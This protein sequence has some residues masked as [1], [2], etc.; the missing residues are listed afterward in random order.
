[1][2]SQHS[3]Q[4]GVLNEV[5]SFD[6]GETIVTTME[7]VKGSVPMVNGESHLG[8]TIW[9]GTDSNKILI[10]AANFPELIPNKKILK[11]TDEIRQ[12]AVVQVPDQVTQ[13]VYHPDGVFVSLKN[14]HL[15]ILRRRNNGDWNLKDSQTIVINADAESISSVVPISNSIYLASGRKINVLTSNT[16]E[17]SK[18]FE[19]ESIAS[20]S[21]GAINLMTHS[22]IGLWVSV[23]QSSVISL[24]HTET[25]KHLQ[26]INIA[27]NVLRV[28]SSQFKGEST[29]NSTICVT[30]LVASRG[31]LWVGTNVGISLTIPLPRLEGVPIISGGVSISYHAHFGPITFLLPLIPKSYSNTNHGIV[32]YSQSQKAATIIEEAKDILKINEPQKMTKVSPSNSTVSSSSSSSASDHQPILMSRRKTLEKQNSIDSPFSAAISSKFRAQFTSSP[33]VLRRQRF[34]DTDSMRMTQTLPRSLGSSAG[35]FS[36]SIH[37]NTSSSSSS[38]GSE[39]NCCDVYGL[40]GDL[41]FVKEDY[42]AED[43]Q[44]NIMD[45]AYESLRRSNPELIPVKVSTLDRRMRMKVARPRSLDLSNWSVDSRSSSLYTSSGSEESMALR[46]Q[47]L[48]QTSSGTISRNSSSASRKYHTIES[49]LIPSVITE[50]PRESS[51][52]DLEQHHDQS[53]SLIPS[54]TGTLRKKSS[55]SNGKNIKHQQPLPEIGG[56][57]T[58]ITLTGGRGY[59][60]WR[61]VWCN[62]TT[63]EKQQRSGSLTNAASSRVPNSNDAHIV[64]WEKKL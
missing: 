33:V 22:G 3:Q 49:Q 39:Q 11:D 10:Y 61:H 29:N 41:I 16:G 13:I 64:V 32:T 42:E 36:Q 57:R 48:T 18:T 4:T 19:I 1:M 17:L 46:M 26:D 56:K 40:Y 31:L 43:G 20:S 50:Q 2:L 55:S 53:P 60:N 14:G 24:Y 54:N 37:S 47:G 34:K 38:Q 30:A 7:F 6:V 21:N 51:N 35:Y 9:M 44:G 27:A 59:I 63:S 5:Y 62:S 23:K 8:D 52:Y 45:T 28:T 15:L 12:L 58:I 25:F